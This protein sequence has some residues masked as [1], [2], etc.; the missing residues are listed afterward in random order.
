MTFS[1]GGAYLAT[2]DTLRSNVVWIWAMEDTPRLESAL[3]HEQ[4]VRQIAW[5][6]L[7]QQLLINTISNTLPAVRCWSP[8]GQPIICRIPTQK[9]DAGKYE[10]KWLSGDSNDHNAFWFGSTEEYVIG[11]LSV[12]DEILHFEVLNSVSNK[13]YGSHAGSLSR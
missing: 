6:S 2:V 7:K 1:A 5:H 8:H 12:A 3:V 4:P 13:G 9:N 10:V 11:Y